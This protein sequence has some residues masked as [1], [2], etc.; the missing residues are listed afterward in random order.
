MYEDL[1]NLSERPAVFSVYTADTLWTEPHLAKMMLDTHLA[2]DT[3]L[4]SRPTKAIDRVV[5]W[6]DDVIG[7]KDRKVCDLGCGPGLYAHRYAK[8]GA[9]VIGLDFSENSIAYA[10][11]HSASK[12]ASVS[13]RVANYL[14]APLPEQ[15]DL[16]TL[17]Y[18]DLCA[19]SPSQRQRLLAKIRDSLVPGGK[20]VFDLYS[21]T[22][23][24]RVKEGVSFGR[25]LMNGFW[26]ENDYFAFQQTFRY[27][28]EAVSLYRFTI[29]EEDRRWD[30]FNW[31]QYF[32]P[33]DI[34]RELEAAGFSSIAFVQGFDLDPKDK[35]S[36]AV[37]AGL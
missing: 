18:C 31:L 12:D 20:F 29:I 5:S 11:G 15:Q 3:A 19:L 34:R 27:E 24:D 1:K 35:A 14:T 23:F 9:N 8:R 37:V 22:A 33:D 10:Q 7:L 36:F 28:S 26:S 2:Q 17:I 32:S 13:Y 25:N 21:E 6:I 16:V 30:V 4:A